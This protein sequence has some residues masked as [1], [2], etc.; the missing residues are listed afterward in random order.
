[1]RTLCLHCWLLAAAIVLPFG[2]WS[3]NVRAAETASGATQWHPLRIGG[4]GWLT[5]IDQSADGSTLLVRTDTYGAYRWNAAQSEWTQLVTAQSMPGRHLEHDYGSGVYEIRVAPNR[6][7]RLYM[8]YRGFIYR[9]DDTGAHWQQ[10]AFAHLTMDANDDF[11]TSGQKLAVDPVNADVVY[12]G[13]ARSGLF[14]TDNGGTTWRPVAGIPASK[15]A[16]PDQYPGH[17]GI[18]FDAASGAISGRTRTI[19]ASSFGN[20]VFRSDDAGTSWH[21]LD[22]GPQSVSHGKIAAD[23]AYYVTSGDRAS[24]WRFAAGAWTEITPEH[25]NWDTI[26]TDPFDAN[27]LLAIREGGYLDISHDRGATWDGIIWG[28]GGTNE[29]LAPNAPW[30]AWT[31]EKYMSTGDMLLDTAK[32]GRLWFAEG[33]GAWTTN[34]AN[35]PASPPLVSFTAQSAGIEQLVANLVV[36]PPGGKP[37]VASWDRP[38]FYIDNPDTYPASHG[39][40]NDKS[41]IAG[42]GLDYATSDPKFLAG[43]FE[44]WGDEKSGFSTD[45]G[46]TWTPFPSVPALERAN[47]GDMAVSSPQNIVWAGSNNERVFVTKDQGQSW[48]PV[49]IDGLPAGPE[50]GWGFAYYL[51]RR[52]VTADRVLPAT[53]YLYNNLRGLYRSSDGGGQWTLMHK[54][55]IVPWSSFNAKLRSVPE[56][57]GHL[58]FTAGPQSGVKPAPSPFRRSIDGGATWT[59]V[60][61]VLEVFAFGFGKPRMPGSYPAIYIAGWVHRTYGLWRSDDA[62]A[63]WVSIGDFPLGNLD[64]VKTID[65]DKDVFGK[66][67]V[68]L[69]GSGYVYGTLE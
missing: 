25:Q 64:E 48:Q 6:P 30:L 41:I 7:E 34:I 2:A 14:Q 17:A 43:I 32:P 4:G 66:V 31:A 67:Y 45:G 53:F 23:G 1:M 46:K 26:V 9:S 58:F 51:N 40:D 61:D 59:S 33:I 3:G 28:P 19:Y 22:G 12:A 36:A 11:R 50:T 20:G 16:K 24:V 10:T 8:A 21:R 60:K 68:G 44:W 65:G 13:T 52:I 57:A 49:S 37:V 55:E 56:R 47:G 27:R 39:P 63:T 38:V 29:R 54:G 5:G 62:A 35:T 15:A 69:S 18:A 42:W